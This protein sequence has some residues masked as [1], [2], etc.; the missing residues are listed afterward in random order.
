MSDEPPV[1][2]KDAYKRAIRAYVEATDWVTFADLHKRFAGDARF[3]TE[4][5]LPG[6]RVVWSGLP[7]PMIA[8]IL[9]LLDERALAAVP[10]HKSA[11]VKDGRVLKLPVEKSVP[12][13]GHDEPHWYPVLLRPM[14]AAVEDAEAE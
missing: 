3:D 1:L 9:E 8:A 13:G 4:M 11:Y 14:R 10:G 2:E 6:K 7:R 12:S 5:A